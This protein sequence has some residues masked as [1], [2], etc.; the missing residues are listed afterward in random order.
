MGI[1]GLWKERVGLP[2]ETVIS[3]YAFGAPPVY[4]ST[5]SIIPKEIPQIHLLVN[6]SDVVPTLSLA[7]VGKV[8]AQLSALDS[9][10]LTFNEKSQII[11]QSSS[12][13]STRGLTNVLSGISKSYEKIVLYSGETK[14]SL[15]SIARS[16]LQSITSLT[17]K[18][19]NTME[20]VRRKRMHAIKKLEVKPCVDKSESKKLQ[21]NSNQNHLIEKKEDQ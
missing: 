10:K 8:L 17:E 3:C 15:I 2:N 5:G 9:L 13:T 6:Q 16:I 1:Y 4:T 11:L 14:S 7:S 20:Y 12:M 19:A 21:I 18:E